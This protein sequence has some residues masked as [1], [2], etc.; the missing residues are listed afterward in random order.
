MKHNDW[1]D[2]YIDYWNS[3]TDEEKEFMLKFNREYHHDGIS[4]YSKDEALLQSEEARQEARRNHNSR[5]T[6]MFHISRKEGN[7]EYDDKYHQFM[8]DACDDWNWERVYS[9][10]GYKGAI[11]FITE[12]T[13]KEIKETNTEPDVI[14]SRYYD[15]RYRLNRIHRKAKK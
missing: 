1:D 7:V 9:I 3:L 4:K 14:L 15:R 13:M 8:N 12:M 11:Q 6:D 10:H 2:S 5:K